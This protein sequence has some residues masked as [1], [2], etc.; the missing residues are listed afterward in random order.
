MKSNLLLSII[1]PVYNVESYLDRCIQSIFKQGLPQDE[2]EIIV[3]DD[4]STDKSYVI[5]QQLQ[6]KHTEIKLY[7]KNNGGLSDARNM[8]LKYAMGQYIMFLDSDDYLLENTLI[9]IVKRAKS[10]D[11]ELCEFLMREYDKNGNYKTTLI[12]PFNENRIY[13]GV[14]AVTGNVT[15]ASVCTILYKKSFLDKYNLK[16]TL[17]LT[18]EDVDFNIRVYAYAKKII[19][20]RIVS[21]VYCWNRDSLNRS[22]EIEFIKRSIL[23]DLKIAANLRNYGQRLSEPL[24]GI[25]KRKSNSIIVSQIINSFFR[26][27]TP[28]SIRKDYV[29]IAREYRL[30]PIHGRTSSWKTT[31][32]IPLINIYIV[33]FE[34]LKR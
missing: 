5:A 15:I 12:Q 22:S 10:E 34:R 9:E 8:G 30:L 17:G 27:S 2:F 20:T 26:N 32:I 7:K 31:V 23:D 28:L 29:H 24:K 1:V 13:T 33:L 14:E 4:G 18:H 25:Y 21:Y 16:F 3:I 6:K 11:V 19:F